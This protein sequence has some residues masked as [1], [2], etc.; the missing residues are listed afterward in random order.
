MREVGCQ[1]LVRTLIIHPKMD[2]KVRCFGSDAK[3]L[4]T[5]R[6]SSICPFNSSGD[7]TTQRKEL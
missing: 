3:G 5:W 7:K 6:G 4:S 2:P 1:E